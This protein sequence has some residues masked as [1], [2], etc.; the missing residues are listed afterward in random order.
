MAPASTR[1]KAIRE[2]RRQRGLSQ[3]DLANALGIRT[4]GTISAWENDKAEID[5]RNLFALTEFFG[6][7]PS[8]L[9]FEMPYTSPGGNMPAWA[10]TIH[11]KLDEIL[12][13]LN[14]LEHQ[15]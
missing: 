2:L 4:Q 3:M 13:R 15:R 5:R 12:R 9:G 8:V 14:D 10:I 7:E 1:G 6:V 11:E